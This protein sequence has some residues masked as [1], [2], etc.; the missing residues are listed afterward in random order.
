MVNTGSAA[1]TVA[2]PPTEG[3]DAVLDIVVDILETDGY[4][5]V[6]LREVARRSRASLATIY[7]R[8]PNRDSLILAALESWMEE[9]RYAGLADQR[10]EPSESLHDGLMR[11]FRTIFE[12]WERHPAMLK[13]FFRARTAPGGERLLHR[14]LDVVI[15]TAMRVL[16][17][18]D[19][20]FIDDLDAIV[21]SLVH[22]LTGRFAADEIAITDILPTIERTVYWL[23]AGYQAG[24]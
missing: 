23:T 19:P 2:Q 21:S 12:P 11:V 1:Q 17:G 7:K 20:G 10:V 4:E 18:V 14:G 5:A 9:N 16:D 8:Y 22:G 24:A 6:Q 13:A 15:P 3:R